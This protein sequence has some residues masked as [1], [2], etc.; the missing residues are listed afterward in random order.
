MV[1]YTSRNNTYRVW[2]PSNNQ[3]TISF[4][5]RFLP[6]DFV[7]T[8][9]NSED[10]GNVAFDINVDNPGQSKTDETTAKV[11]DHKLN[12][13]LTMPIIRKPLDLEEPNLMASDL[14]NP[15]DSLTEEDTNREQNVAH[16]PCPTFDDLF[17]DFLD[18]QRNFY[19]GVNQLLDKRDHDNH[20]RNTT[21]CTVGEINSVAAHSFLIQNLT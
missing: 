11:Y 21:P 6:S 2:S 20:A 10:D 15:K 12:H 13:L 17:R 9:T 1:G 19:A 5:L 4:D 18:K 14:E 16:E 7:P 3:V 8:N